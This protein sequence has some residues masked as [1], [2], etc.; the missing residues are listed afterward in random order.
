MGDASGP[1]SWVGKSVGGAVVL[2][3]RTMFGAR[4]HI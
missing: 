2:G 3:L 4:R 1:R